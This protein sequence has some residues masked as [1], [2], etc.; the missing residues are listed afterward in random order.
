METVMIIQGRTLS[1]KD[2]KFISALIS[3]NPSFSRRRIS[4]DICKAWGWVTPYGQL[5]D[6]ACRTMLLKLEK[7]GYITL[8]RSRNPNTN[9]QRM[10]KE[11]HLPHDTTPITGSLKKYSPIKIETICDELCVKLF[12]MYLKNYHY[13]G[14]S[15]IVG[16]NI[17][18][19]VYD[20]NNTPLACLLFGA[21]A[22]KTAP[23]D[24]FIGWPCE[25]Q[26]LNL[27]YIT[28][29]SRYL[30]F[31]WVKVPHLASHILGNVARRISHDWQLKYHH[32]VHLL[33]TF[34]SKD[35]YRGTCYRAA[36]WICVGETKGRGKNSISRLATL[37]VK[38]VW[39]YPLV[40]N[41]KE[42]LC[43]YSGENVWAG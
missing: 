19:M 16:E 6:M 27:Q 15:T 40:N 38:S 36:N 34:V 23:R 5:K 2:I 17:K 20:R 10:Q 3:C 21:A 18:Y 7:A 13:L 31:P 22:W 25:I 14:L 29:N 28:N 26:K 24:A 35:K 8:P 32:P 4:R 30:I 12:R 43:S 9:A 33:E 42:L 39:L 11:I 37:P 1:L 41:F